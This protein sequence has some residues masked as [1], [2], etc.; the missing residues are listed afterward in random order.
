MAYREHEVIVKGGHYGDDNF[1]MHRGERTGASEECRV[2]R[3]REGATNTRLW[4]LWIKILHKQ[5]ESWR[6]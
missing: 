6:R 5:S 3:S 2:E 4:D 1:I